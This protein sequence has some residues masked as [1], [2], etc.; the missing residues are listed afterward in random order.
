[1]IA[2][3]GGLIAI[4]EDLRNQALDW[5]FDPKFENYLEKQDGASTSTIR[6]PVGRDFG[7]QNIIAPVSAVIAPKY[8][9]V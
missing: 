7:A 9:K 3:Y 8:L 2:A 4:I 6:R 1:V 5:G